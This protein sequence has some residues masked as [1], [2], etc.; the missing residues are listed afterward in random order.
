MWVIKSDRISDVVGYESDRILAM[1]LILPSQSKNTN[2]LS[3]RPSRLRGSFNRY[4]FG[5][6]VCGGVIPAVR[7]AIAKRSVGIAFGIC[8]LWGCDSASAP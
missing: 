8:A 4:S 6:V 3:S 7:F 1:S 5:V 2:L